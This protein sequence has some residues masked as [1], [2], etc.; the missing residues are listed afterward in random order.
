MN[1]RDKT[2]REKSRRAEGVFPAT[3]QAMEA[4]IAELG[5]RN[6]WFRNSG[7]SFAAEILLRELLTNAVEHGSNNDPGRRVRCAFRLRGGRL[8]IN[9]QDEGA[10]FN[11]RDAIGRESESS[12]LSGRGLEI[13]RTHSTAF[14]FN[15]K[16][17][18]VTVRR[19]FEMGLCQ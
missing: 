12:D 3:L 15:K 6:G 14:R 17:N 1:S 2:S 4:F 11:W 19:Q 9:V 10:G 8:T 13:L 16:G 5:L 7:D 18:S